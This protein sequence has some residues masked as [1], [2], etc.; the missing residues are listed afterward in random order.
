MHGQNHIKSATC[1]IT[2]YNTYQLDAQITIY[3]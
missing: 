2:L 3:S 1:C